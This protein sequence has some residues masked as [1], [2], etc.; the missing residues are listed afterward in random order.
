MQKLRLIF[1]KNRPWEIPRADTKFRKYIY[2][3]LIERFTE[4]QESKPRPIITDR[5][6]FA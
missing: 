3:N 2:L 4:R 1:R 6:A 5:T